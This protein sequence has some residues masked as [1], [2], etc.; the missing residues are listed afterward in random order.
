MKEDQDNIK[1]YLSFNDLLHTPVRFAILLYLLSNYNASFPEIKHALD[2]TS[3]NLSSHIKKLEQA[4]LILI[5]KLFI[6]AKPTTI[7]SLTPLGRKTVSNYME[8]LK[9]LLS[10]NS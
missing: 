8:T 6:N 3:G 10:N 4:N 9:S 7:L 2:L 5:N 1:N